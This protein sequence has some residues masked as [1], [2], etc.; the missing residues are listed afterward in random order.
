[1]HPSHPLFSE[2]ER[3][4]A[5]HR[6]RRTPADDA[7]DEQELREYLT[8]RGRALAQDQDLAHATDQELETLGRLDCIAQHPTLDQD[9]AT[10]LEWIKDIRDQHSLLPTPELHPETARHPEDPERRP[11]LDGVGAHV[12]RSSSGETPDRKEPFDEVKWYLENVPNPD[13]EKWS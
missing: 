12:R 2:F 10:R 4:W 11:G 8:R 5:E 6:A 3:Q 9:W 1:M 13:D 7:R